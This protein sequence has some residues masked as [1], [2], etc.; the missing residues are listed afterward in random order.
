MDMETEL[1]SGFL[2]LFGSK[3]ELAVKAPGRVN[4]IGEHTD[5]NEGF[6]LPV[7]VNRSIGIAARGRQDQ[8]VFLYSLNFKEMASFSLNGFG[9]DGSWADY[10]KGVIH[11]YQKLGE[12]VSGFDAV[13]YGDIPLGAGLSSSAAFEVATAYLLAKLNRIE[14]EPEEMARLCQRAENLYVGVNCGIMD[15]F[16][17]VLGKRGHALFLDCRDL[18]FQYASIPTDEVSVVVCD[19]GVR[20]GLSDSEYNLRRSQCE[21]GAKRLATVLPGAKAL[22]D[23]SLEQFE[24]HQGLLPDGMRKM[25]R[26]VISE[27][28]RVKEAVVALRRGDVVRFGQL[29]N[30]SHQSLRDEFQVSCRELD[31][32]VEIARSVDGVLGARLTGAGFG[33][34]TVNLVRKRSAQ[35]LAQTV[36]EKYEAETGIKPAVYPCQIEDGVRETS[37]TT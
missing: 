28:W 29:M 15:Q 25:C 6:V 30:L 1:L 19:S 18:S 20:R 8:Q 12:Y 11:E 31:L 7:A 23:I 27:N 22:R 32:L 14:I 35:L 13:V 3:P 21:Q 24:E 5:Y 2:Q 16:I 37:I 9:K 4:L 10:P 36:E 17:A 34:C 26:H 33:G